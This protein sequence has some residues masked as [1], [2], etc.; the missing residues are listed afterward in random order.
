MLI[1]VHR[2][3]RITLTV[4][5]EEDTV[6]G[7]GQCDS[8][9]AYDLRA[10]RLVCY[11]YVVRVYSDEC[12]VGRAASWGHIGPALGADLGQFDLDPVISAAVCDA[13]ST[14]SGFRGVLSTLH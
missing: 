12:I 3:G 8:A 9:T 11:G 4:S 1:S 10:G 6:S 2:N 7:L 13:K 14:L 5:A